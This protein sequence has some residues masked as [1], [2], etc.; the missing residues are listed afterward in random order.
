MILNTIKQKNMLF[1]LL[2][3][4]SFT[5]TSLALMGTNSSALLP[6]LSSSSSTL[7]NPFDYAPIT[8]KTVAATIAA[9][10]LIYYMGLDKYSNKFSLRALERKTIL[11][12]TP[13][14]R[15]LGILGLGAAGLYYGC[16]GKLFNLI[17][18]KKFIIGAMASGVFFYFSFRKKLD[19][20]INEER[21]AARQAIQE[22]DEVL[23]REARAIERES[24]AATERVRQAIERDQAIQ[25][26][27][28]ARAER[29]QEH[30][31]VIKLKQDKLFLQ[32]ESSLLDAR[33]RNLEEALA[34]ARG[35]VPQAAHPV[36]RAAEDHLETQLR[37]REQDLVRREQD[38]V[39]RE[40]DLV[41][42]EQDLVEREQEV[43]T[44]WGRIQE[45]SNAA[46]KK[47]EITM[48]LL[49]AVRQQKING[50]R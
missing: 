25:E 24:Q 40:Q 31:Q 36:A 27:N 42:R 41:E 2:L 34:E 26:R 18:D 28:A 15:V 45:F 11:C 39:E 35:Q 29:D 13:T 50:S 5:E 16:S 20:A 1:F 3:I 7:Q 37:P 49:D 30:A 12:P 33:I 46:D 4:H 8:A 10:S 6:S 44:A 21:D 32:A 43:M 38:L 47:F 48:E 17:P 22:R 14:A 9:G 23:R 19:T